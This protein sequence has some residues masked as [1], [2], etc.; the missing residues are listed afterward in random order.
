[1]LVLVVDRR[2]RV[3]DQTTGQ[4]LRELTLDPTRDYQPQPRNERCPE[5]SQSASGGIRT[6]TSEDTGS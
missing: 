6:H 1:V 4:L 5:T 3:L 2:I